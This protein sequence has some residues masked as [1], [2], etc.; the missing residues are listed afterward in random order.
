VV[1][2]PKRQGQGAAQE[3]PTLRCRCRRQPAAPRRRPV[4]RGCQAAASL[5]V[6]LADQRHRRCSCLGAGVPQE[7]GPQQHHVVFSRVLPSGASAVAP[8]NSLPRCPALEDRRGP[9]ES[10]PVPAAFR[11]RSRPPAG[12]DFRRGRPSNVAIPPYFRAHPARHTLSASPAPPKARFCGARRESAK[13]L[14]WEARLTPRPPRCRSCGLVGACWV[15]GAGSRWHGKAISAFCHNAA[16]A[17]APPAAAC[18]WQWVSAGGTAAAR[19]ETRRGVPLGWRGRDAGLPCQR[20]PRLWPWQAPGVGCGCQNAAP[21]PTTAS[22]WVIAGC[23]WWGRVRAPCL[24]PTALS[25]T[26]QHRPA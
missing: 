2:L 19:G 25:T 7:G 8:L 26:Q 21:H 5:P 1:Q 6:V 17:P 15:A 16:R 24:P 20:A 22:L 3:G 9:A 12:R 11:A 18:D 14:R 23:D 10:S 13:H 4:L